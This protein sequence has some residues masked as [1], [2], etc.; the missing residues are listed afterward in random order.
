MDSTIGQRWN[1]TSEARR[2]SW[3]DKHFNNFIFIFL[4]TALLDGTKP[5]PVFGL[6]TATDVLIISCDLSKR[7]STMDRIEIIHVM[8]WH[9]DHRKIN[10]LKT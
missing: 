2:N 9:Y 7:T 4:D 5:N 1:N 8:K 10:F 3:S 6:T